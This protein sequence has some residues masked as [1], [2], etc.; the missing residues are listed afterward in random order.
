MTFPILGGNGVTAGYSIDNSL[1]FNDGDS[2]YL[3]RTPSSAGNRKTFTWSAW[4]KRSAIGSSSRRLFS[5]SSSSSVAC[6]IGFDSNN[7]FQVM[8]ESISYI[9]ATDQVFRD[10][11]AYY[12]FVVAVDTTQA[13]SSN[14]VKLYVNGNQITNFSTETYPSQ[15]SNGFINNN[16]VHRIGSR[17]QTGT[18]S[19]EFF[20]GYMAEVHFI[21]GT[22]KSPTDFGE[23]DEDSGIW[24]PIQYTG[25]YGTNGFYL[26]FENSGS[27]GADQSGNSNDFTPTNLASTDQTTDTPTNN[28]ATLN[29]LSADNATLSE[30]NVEGVRT[31]TGAISVVSTIAPTSG[32]WYVEF[33]NTAAQNTSIGVVNLDDWASGT[34]IYDFS[35]S[36]AVLIESNRNDVISYGNTASS[37][38]TLQTSTDLV[39]AKYGLAIDIDNNDLYVSANGNWY[40]GSSFNQSDFSNA[41]AVVT[42]LPSNVPL[43]FFVRGSLSNT[44]YVNFG[45]AGGDDTI[46]SGNSDGNGYGNFEYAPPS[47]YLALC[48]QNLATALSPT[49]D[50]GSQYFSS[51][52]YTGDGTTSNAITGVG[53]Q[54]DFAWF[55]ARSSAYSHM[56]F[57]STRGG[58]ARLN[59]DATYAESTGSDR[60]QSFDSDG[61]TISTNTAMNNSGTSFVVWSWLASGGTTSSNTDGSIT[62]TVQTGAGFSIVTWTGNA[63]ASATVGHG[64]GVAP[65]VVIIK[66]RSDNESWWVGHQ[67]AGSIGDGKYLLLN[68]TAAVGTNN[69]SFCN[70]NPTTTTFKA[71]GSTS[72]DNAING[73]G[74]NMLAYCFAPIEG[75]SKFGSY[76]GNGNNDGIF[77]YTGFRPAWLMIKRT[78][79]TGGAAWYIFDNKRN[80]FNVV[81][82]R[83]VAQDVDTEATNFDALDFLSNGFKFRNNDQGWNTSGGTYIYM[84]FAES[85]FCTSTGIPVTA[86]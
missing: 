22:A 9:L 34:D 76:T 17:Y 1:R 19:S 31:T 67:G 15:N 16:I 14:R 41:T 57:D 66:N 48:T 72:A 68:S 71:G 3:T 51:T 24:K 54:G 78:D 32:K 6:Q 81:K 30:G 58:D 33:K 2:P 80:T 55:K 56:L 59:S 84:A 64:L 46:S 73:S 36:A 25:S 45:N 21:D 43:A 47:G 85:P 65:E 62:S 69:T 39:T 7:I 61:Y 44:F 35:E 11:S 60:I 4:I 63:T 40:G 53:F 75:Y 10:V 20:D 13:T 29:P 86:R 12:H 26:D 38:T 77:V 79:S 50:D 49:I 42:D 83:L 52:L 23:Y 28:F 37:P 18:G 82:N 8:D 74:D 5:A 27:L 70:A